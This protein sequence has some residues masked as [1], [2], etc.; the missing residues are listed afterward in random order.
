MTV[1]YWPNI[2]G[3]KELFEPYP[4]EIEQLQLAEYSL[5]NLEKLHVQAKPS[6]YSIRVNGDKRILFTEFNGNLLLLDVVENHDYHKSRFLKHPRVLRNYLNKLGAAS[7]LDDVEIT[8]YSVADFVS[9][10]IVD[11][12]NAAAG[13]VPTP[14]QAIYPY[15]H[16]LIRLN[17]DQEAVLSVQPP[18]I[19]H[20]PAGSG[21][22]CVGFSALIDRVRNSGP[23]GVYVSQSPDLVRQM[24]QYWQELAELEDIPA[25]AVRFMTY[26]ELAREQLG[27]AQIKI[28][29]ERHFNNWYTESDAP[30]IK[31]W[32]DL[33]TTETI[34]Q[35]FRI[36]SGYLNPD[37]YLNLGA[38]QSMVDA[39][40]RAIIVNLYFRYLTYLKTQTDCFSLAFHPFEQRGPYNF[41]VVDEAQDLSCAQLRNL[42]T[43]CPDILYLLGE[44]QILYDG[45]SRS[46]FLKHLFYEHQIRIDE[47]NVI[48]LPQAYRSAPEVVQVAN[49]LIDMKYDVTG[50]ATDKNETRVI[51]TVWERPEKGDVKWLAPNQ[52][53]AYLAAN[54]ELDA[55]VAIITSP[56]L[57]EAAHARF[58]TTTLI[59]SWKAA[60]GLE[61]PAVLLWLPLDDPRA[62]AISKKDLVTHKTHRGRAKSGQ[63]DDTHVA[64]FDAL[65]TAVTRAQR[66]LVVVQEKKHNLKA[67]INRWSKAFVSQTSTPAPVNPMIE[68]KSETQKKREWEER[69]VDLL[70]QGYTH[71][72]RGIL[73]KQLSLNPKAIA[74][75]L[76]KHTP[77]ERADEQAQASGS[78]SV[79]PSAATSSSSALPQT[80]AVS[81]NLPIASS[82]NPNNLE[83]DAKPA[84]KSQPLQLLLQ[85]R[86]NAQKGQFKQAEKML[87][88]SGF[89]PEQTHKQMVKWVLQDGNNEALENLSHRYF[90]KF[91]D[92]MD[93][94]SCPLNQFSVQQRNVFINALQNKL[95][96]II[97]THYDLSNLF[98]LPEQLLTTQHRTLIC[99]SL[100]NGRSWPFVEYGEDLVNLFKQPLNNFSQKQ[101]NILWQ[102]TT[103]LNLTKLIT[104]GTE[105][106][107]LFDLPDTHFSPAQRAEM[108]AVMKNRRQ[109]IVSSLIDIAYL[110]ALPIAIFSTTQRDI[111]W[112]ATAQDVDSIIENSEYDMFLTF[113][114][115]VE[116]QLPLDQRDFIFY[117]ILKNERIFNATF[118]TGEAIVN[119]F[120]LPFDQFPPAYR[121][122][123]W[124]KLI[125]SHKLP[126]LI[127]TLQDFISLFGLSLEQF[128]ESM[129][130][131][132][133]TALQA[134]PAQLSESNQPDIN[135]LFELDKALFTDEQRLL[136]PSIIEFKPDPVFSDERSRFFSSSATLEANRAEYES[137]D[138]HE[139]IPRIH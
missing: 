17:P 110:Y 97:V 84:V 94:L 68:I 124:S 30:D 45:K 135:V 52:L 103:L 115:L 101:R 32:R 39:G 118:D 119:F 63:R 18:A 132:L 134:H 98:S 11:N 122:S 121:E 50:G 56:E 95:G 109:E 36:C 23:G 117:N 131:E 93:L 1:Y 8:A 58:P 61:F 81:K 88:K 12:I 70:Q 38:K 80:A 113:F 108:W 44:H 99:K 6:I 126:A 26:E 35:E 72:A 77:H 3:S 62:V 49:A 47:T 129:R 136:F 112:R 57:V 64:Y 14:L 82:V 78:Q 100:N 33:L 137:S 34:W 27:A 102:M 67:F 92:V 22:S 71:H 90:N 7:S 19:I 130:M 16:Q 85:A 10:D 60:K 74:T 43:L 75:W 9:C 15:H 46:E 4:R 66:K 105:L 69:A 5:L 128:P 114:E 79:A 104:S 37:E 133:L 40:T 107:D 65:I 31:E 125:T 20:G 91:Q 76:K 138:T 127:S 111:V 54:G 29:D 42:F 89:N 28:A 106:A 2:I 51:N 21:K 48:S 25:D 13:N 73:E 120:V 116:D 87:L 83:A 41:M 123:I 53:D 96:S 86:A 55:S 24:R 139:S 59:F